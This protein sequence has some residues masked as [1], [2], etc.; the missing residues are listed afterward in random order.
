MSIKLKLRK[1]YHPASVKGH[2]HVPCYRLI[3]PP[4]A[5]DDFTVCT[6]LEDVLGIGPQPVGTEL[7][8]IIS[9]VRKVVE[10]ELL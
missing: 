6:K 10:K 3:E 1:S 4:N 5:A 8:V 9:S 2:C 7:T